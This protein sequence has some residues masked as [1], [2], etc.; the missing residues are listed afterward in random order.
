MGRRYSRMDRNVNDLFDKYDSSAVTFLFLLI[1]IGAWPL[2][3]LL[4]VFGFIGS[5]ISED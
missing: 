5:L 4:V 3:V 1:L 2:A